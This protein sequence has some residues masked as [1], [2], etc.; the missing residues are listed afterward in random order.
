MKIVVL[1][2]KMLNPGD[3][4]WESLRRLGEV[5]IYDRTANDQIIMR[6]DD[7][8]MILTNKTPIRKETL[9]QVGNLRYIGVLATGYDVVDIEYARKKG[10]TVSNVPAYSTNSVAQMVFALLLEI[11]HHV[12]DHSQKTKDGKWSR[13]VDFS[14][15]DHP[16]Y[17][18]KDKTLGIIGYGQTG[19]KTAEIAEAFGMNVLV[20]TRTV[21]K[22]LE[23][24]RLSF[25]SLDRLYSES[26]VISLHCPS[27]ERTKG[28]I[29]KASISKMKK[30]VILINTAR[31]ALINEQDLAEAL[32]SSQV[33]YA[34]VDVLSKEP[35]DINN[36][37]LKAQNCFITPHIAWATKEA[38]QRLME[39][40]VNNIMKFQEGTPV[41][42]V[43]N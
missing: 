41:N 34:A 26:D 19:R 21:D 2:G 3:L 20:H 31:G 36:P 4:S 40:T 37:L 7:A 6:I 22:T 28:M 8:E 27:T 13:S 14:F 39:I 30:G 12:G 18:L 15:F 35:A 9:D 25:V 32:E 38:R 24:S 33:A 29:D 23:N 5:T 42:V 11:C 43:N 16:L 1:D 17:E 10:I